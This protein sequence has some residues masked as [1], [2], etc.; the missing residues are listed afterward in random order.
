[1]A[2]PA[3]L[4]GADRAAIRIFGDGNTVQYAPR[5]GDPVT[6]TG[7]FDAAYVRVDE[8]RAGIVSS[9]PALFC[10]LSDLPSDPELDEDP[11]VTVDGV[12]YSIK[13]PQK[14]G[15]GGVLMLLR[16]RED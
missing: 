4:E 9:G 10:R 12:N 2:W 5:N 14:D 3:L 15:Q 7:I 11:T 16:L 1:M 13:E 6:V 8:G